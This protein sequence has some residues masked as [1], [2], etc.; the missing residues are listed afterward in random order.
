MGALYKSDNSI[1]NTIYHNDVGLLLRLEKQSKY[2][3]KLLPTGGLPKPRNSYYYG[4][5]YSAAGVTLY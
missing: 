1:L 3:S 5:D 2:P 4:L